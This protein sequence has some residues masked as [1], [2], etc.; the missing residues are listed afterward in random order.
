MTTLYRKYRPQRFSELFGQEHIK[1]TIQNQ[2]KADRVGH[3]YLFCGPRGV[4]KTTMA[5]LL[6]KSINC[7]NR[8]QGEFEPCNKCESCLEVM[9][10]RS[11]DVI[12]IDAA[13]NTG[14]EN[15]REH[16]INS[17][18][19]VPNLRKYKVFIIDEVHMLSTSAFNALLKILEE[20]PEYVKFILA[21]TE[22]HKI[23]PT[24]ISRC[25]RFDFQKLS[26]KDLKQRLKLLA[27]Q[28]KKEVDDFVFDIIIKNSDG[29][30]RDAESLLGQVLILDDEKITA[31]HIS[32]I[33][34]VTNYNLVQEF[35]KT[36]ADKN[37]K[38]AIQFINDLVERGINIEQFNRDLIEYLRKILL[39]SIYQSFENI[40]LDIDESLQDEVIKLSNKFTKEQIVKLID[41]F[42]KSLESIKTS[43]I[44][45]L[46]LE[47]AVIEIF[48]YVLKE[49][50]ESNKE[51]GENHKDSGLQRKDEI[52]MKDNNTKDFS[53]DQQE[54]KEQTENK[55]NELKEEQSKDQ[56]KLNLQNIKNKWSEFLQEV[57][58][59]N[60]GLSC[61]LSPGKL[62]DFRDNKLIIAFK[63][64]FNKDKLSEN[65]NK[66][67]IKSA[68]RKVY[69]QDLGIEFVFDKNLDVDIVFEQN[70]EQNFIKENNEKFRKVDKTEKNDN[71][72]NSLDNVLNLF[73]GE[74]VS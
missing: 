28:E 26:K 70:L 73:G 43:L 69:K 36:F 54:K 22:V 52:K 41:I 9:E 20:P 8:Q 2:I 64:R 50:E 57:K 63:H 18:R 66:S 33:L 59:L 14:V 34:P 30:L 12:E 10:S 4:G 45:Q 62:V 24:I 32:M 3:A 29:C 65:K 39:Y 71:S 7:L 35:L 55:E 27:E 56:Q 74:I 19:F 25:Q 13:S 15:V 53:S 1:Q 16:I 72:I 46:P 68:I 23:L 6:A 5:R 60:S 67:K 37:L 51:K 44:D 47:I 17:A 49:D 11:L 38:N 48:E 61:I 40:D 58:E 21:T 31:D 42:I